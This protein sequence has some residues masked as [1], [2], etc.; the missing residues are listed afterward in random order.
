MSDAEDDSMA[1]NP[2]SPRADLGYDATTAP[3]LRRRPAG[4]A[5]VWAFVERDGNPVDHGVAVGGGPHECRKC[6]ERAPVLHADPD[7]TGP[8][9]VICSRCT[10]DAMR[11]RIGWAKA[12]D[13]KDPRR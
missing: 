13:P 12:S 6:R 4:G 2:E 3:R 10:G 7:R 11:E 8:E 1:A 9:R 5:T